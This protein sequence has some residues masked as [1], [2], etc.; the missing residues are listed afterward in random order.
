M[1]GLVKGRNVQEDYDSLNEELK[2][3]LVKIICGMNDDDLTT[4]GMLTKVDGEILR[5]E[6]IDILKKAVA[7]VGLNCLRYAPIEYCHNKEKILEILSLFD[8]K[9]TRASGINFISE[10][11]QID[12]DV[13]QA[14]VRT[15]PFELYFIITDLLHTDFFNRTNN[16]KLL[17]KKILYFCEYLFICS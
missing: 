5:I 9:H 11:L 16:T 15:Q 8:I 2:V 6:D 10:E 7:S 1:L 13:L 17:C 14:L 12:V 4:L 3:E